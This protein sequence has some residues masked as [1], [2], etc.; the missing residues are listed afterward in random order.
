MIFTTTICCGSSSNGGNG[1][2]LAALIYADN[3]FDAQQKGVSLKGFFLASEV[4]T[5]GVKYGT[6]VRR[7][8]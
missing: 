2:D 5:M 4:N 8:F 6:V 7:E 3:D 1:T